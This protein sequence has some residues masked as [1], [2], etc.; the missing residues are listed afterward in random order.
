MGVFTCAVVTV[1]LTRPSAPYL[2]RIKK[3]IPKPYSSVVEILLK[4][5][6]LLAADALAETECSLLLYSFFS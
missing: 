2:V 3:Y 5:T 1:D 6:T 4:E